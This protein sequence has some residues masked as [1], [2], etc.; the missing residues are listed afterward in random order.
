[1]ADEKKR[2]KTKGLLTIQGRSR[3]AASLNPWLRDGFILAALDFS[4][5][6][7]ASAHHAAKILCLRRDDLL[8]LG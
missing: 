4:A 5:Y 7:P 2:P 3:S 1:M 6:F 8:V